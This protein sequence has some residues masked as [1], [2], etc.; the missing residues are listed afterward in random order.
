MNNYHY[1]LPSPVYGS[2]PRSTFPA[3]LLQLHFK[4]HVGAWSRS[5]FFSWGWH[6]HDALIL[7]QLFQQIF[8]TL[9]YDDMLPNQLLSNDP[10][11]PN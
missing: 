6:K 5:P 11:E 7:R 8:R 9:S 4:S 1:G 2:V 3:L 10:Q